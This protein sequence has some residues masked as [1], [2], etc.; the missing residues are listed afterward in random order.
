[1]FE[2]LQSELI[3]VVKNEQRKR[4]TKKKRTAEAAL[5]NSAHY[6]QVQANG[7]AKNSKKRLEP[8]AI[9]SQKRVRSVACL[10]EYVYGF[11]PGCAFFGSK[12]TGYTR[13]WLL[14]QT[15]TINA[16][17][18]YRRLE[19]TSRDPVPSAWAPLKSIQQRQ[20]HSVGAIRVLTENWQIS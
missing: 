8:S 17:C 16:S 10:V 2:Y 15:N 3:L 6:I 13:H 11:V 4:K 18:T 9:I 19:P 20:P 14:P 12:R 7:Y 5:Q 1:M